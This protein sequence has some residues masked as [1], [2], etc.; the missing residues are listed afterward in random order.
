MQTT[1]KPRYGII[2]TRLG[3]ESTV[4]DIKMFYN[5]WHMLMDRSY[6][7][8]CGNNEPH[9]LL[10]GFYRRYSISGLHPCI[11]GVIIDYPVTWFFFQYTVS[12]RHSYWINSDG[13]EESKTGF[14]SMK[15]WLKR[16]IF[17]WENYWATLIFQY[18]W[19]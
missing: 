9:E 8:S 15:I 2:M 1:I 19:K 17:S 18:D 11:Q 16:T 3:N 4:S 5:T 7:V 6:D 10:N 13:F 14:E 12:C